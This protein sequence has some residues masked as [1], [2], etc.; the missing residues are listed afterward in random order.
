MPSEE[1]IRAISLARAG[2]K[3]SARHILLKIVQEEP[4]NEMAWIWLVDTMPTDAQRIS[5]LKQC[6]RNLPSSQ[7]ARRALETILARQ[8]SENEPGEA[9][10]ETPPAEEASPG[11][12]PGAGEPFENAAPAEPLP[13]GKT[14]FSS[15]PPVEPASTL[16]ETGRPGE[17]TGAGPVSR[18][19][20]A[21]ANPQRTN[22]VIAAFRNTPEPQPGVT[23]SETTER[24]THQ[25]PDFRRILTVAGFT[26]LLVAVIFLLVLYLTSPISPLQAIAR[27]NAGAVHTP[28]P[29]QS[30]LFSTATLVPGVTPTSDIQPTP[31]PP[32]IDLGGKTPNSLIWS[33]DGTFLAVASANGITFYDAASYSQLGSILSQEPIK[34]CSLSPDMQY[35]A[36]GGSVLNIWNVSDGSLAASYQPQDA[37]DESITALA[38]SPAGDQIALALD[39]PS[40]QIVFWSIA[41]SD[42]TGTAMPLQV[43]A[44]GMAYSSTNSDLVVGLVDGELLVQEPGSTDLQT[45]QEAGTELSNTLQFAVSGNQVAAAGADRQVTLFALDSGRPIGQLA[46][47]ANIRA[48]AFSPNGNLLAIG[49]DN[50]LT[51]IWLMS[52]TGTTNSIQMMDSP[53]VGLAFSPDG[54]QLAIAYQQGYVAVAPTGN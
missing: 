2:E 27:R 10:G 7:I 51:D 52:S 11:S 14:P 20:K 17:S 43:T 50:N 23:V 53:V 15:I 54:A 39:L 26:V 25:R 33:P 42:L 30:D 16:Q 34:N 6:L 35:L 38:F 28:Y 3:D 12:R 4:H 22:E 32:G 24:R 46:V 1:L 19:S 44:S 21:P 18:P 13:A 36:C 48:L 41:G 49:L 5:T 31:L 9:G 29:T 47:G 40:P 45:L 37:E 8:Q